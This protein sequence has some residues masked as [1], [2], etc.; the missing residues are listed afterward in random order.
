MLDSISDLICKIGDPAEACCYLHPESKHHKYATAASTILAEKIVE[1]NASSTLA[2]AGLYVINNNSDLTEEEYAVA[3]QLHLES[4]YNKPQSE[5]KREKLNELQSNVSLATF[6]WRDSRSGRKK[7]SGNSLYLTVRLLKA[8]QELAEF[9]DYE[10]F[11][12]MESW[13][14]EIKTPQEV[15]SF[16]D[17]LRD[18]LEP[19]VK[20]ELELLYRLADES[21]IPRSLIEKEPLTSVKYATR[22]LVGEGL[23][24]KMIPFFSLQNVLDGIAIV[25]K[26]AFGV[27][28][29]YRHDVG[30]AE[31]WHPSVFKADLIESNGDYIG[32]VYFDLFNR[33]F[34]FTGAASFPLRLRSENTYPSVILAMNIALPNRGKPIQLS[35]SE[36]STVFHEWGHIL[37]TSLSK[38][39]LQ[40]FSG[41]RGAMDF[42]ETPSTLFEN[43]LN[44]YRVTRLWAKSSSGNVLPENLLHDF[45]H[46]RPFIGIESAFPI[47]LSAV[48]QKLHSGRWDSIENV[49]QEMHNKYFKLPSLGRTEWLEDFD[50][51]I[52]YGSSYYSYTRC[53]TLSS[54]IWHKLFA[55]DPLSPDAG[56]KY[57][58]EFLQYGGYRNSSVIIKNML[59]EDPTS[60]YYIDRIYQ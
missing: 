45:T 56:S 50:H 4:Y 58:D 9:L 1:L 41:M 28:I 44:D 13:H 53:E 36:A 10:S 16:L 39:K 14:R 27:D 32:S 21:K 18:Q 22:A 60:K 54:H 49:V 52:G 8:R 57:R 12:H 31:L 5:A 51:L 11:S 35:Y 42:I 20:D 30:Q 43:F 59:G 24:E 40:H 7:S 23:E 55:D 37:Q 19:K 48:D 15:F 38:N 47:A 3:K 26:Q 6:E 46:K 33:D 25:T 2:E 17:G 29:V 34:K